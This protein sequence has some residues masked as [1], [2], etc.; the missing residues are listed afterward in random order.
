MWFLL[1]ESH[2]DD[3]LLRILTLLSNLVQ[4]THKLKHNAAA[5]SN[6]NGDSLTTHVDHLPIE[7]GNANDNDDTVYVEIFF[8]MHHFTLNLLR[9]ASNS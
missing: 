9:L 7:L 2:P 6:G 4:T 3:Q 8:P 1:D 5:A